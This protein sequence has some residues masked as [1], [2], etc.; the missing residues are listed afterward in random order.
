MINQADKIAVTSRS[1][2]T[3]PVLRQA[4][5]KRYQDIIFNDQGLK[6]EGDQLIF[7][8]E[9]CTKAIIGLEKFNH[10]NLSKL[11]MLNTLSRFGVGLDGID[12]DALRQRHIKL[13]F[14]P[15]VNR[16]AVAELALS[17][18]LLLLRK[19]YF[20]T[21]QL[22]N[23][24][25]KKETG[26]ELTGKT[27]G[28]IGANHIGKEL[29]QLL[30]PFSC[31]ILIYDIVKYENELNK[32]HIHQVSF[33]ELIAQSDIITLHVPSTEKTY[34]MINESVLNAMK[35]TVFLI[36]TAR[37]NIIDQKAL[38]IA[39]IQ[40]KIAGAALDVFESE[41]CSDHELLTLPNLLCTPHIA[42]NTIE[43]ELAMG[44]A[45][46]EGLHHATIP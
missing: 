29:I 14:L 37:G 9:G 7:F 34:H 16:R 6:L 23:G 17:Y 20:M 44:L 8:L 15:G 26:H 40:G 41:P 1:F 3:N 2:S 22:K 13:A 25:W 24:I 38:K 46:I 21:Q 28:I 5:Q 30:E 33:N 19:T 10:T 18:M 35:K 11:P 42:G 27:I 12:F 43:S 36:N 4:L 45:A 32:N 39:L 31:T